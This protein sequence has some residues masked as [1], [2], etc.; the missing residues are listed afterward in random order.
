M[1]EGVRDFVK[2][3]RIRVVSLHNYCPIPPNLKRCQA[4]PDCYSMASLDEGE[5]KKAL[6]YTKNSIA[7]AK[8]LDAQAVVLHCGR[9]E[10]PDRTRDLISL[11]RKGQRNNRQY[12]L[13][14]ERA[15]RERRERA[16]EF[17]RAALKSL[18]ELESY[19]QKKGIKLGIE[20]RFYYR[21][22][23]SFEETGLI[24]E[25][26]QN[27][28]IFYWHDTG[29]AQLMQDLGFSRH[30][31]YLDA[32]AGRMLGIHLHGIADYQDHLAPGKGEL[33]FR[34][35]KPYL[36]QGI[37]KVIEAHSSATPEDLKKSRLFLEKIFN[38]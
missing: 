22:I 14:N 17:L 3:G 29:H 7:T 4:L 1:V 10:V 16:P 34:F 18:K 5:R 8:S 26:F 37:L 9:V 15:V 24:L 28:N 6:K 23:P 30:R 11:C 2:K 35:L 25:V 33:D 13:L 32:Y 21:E 36:K 19:A 38:V 31:D 12:R 27:S 20:T